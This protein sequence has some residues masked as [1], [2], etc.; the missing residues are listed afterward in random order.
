MSL[1]AFEGVLL[2]FLSLLTP[3]VMLKWLSSYIH[4]GRKS[5]GQILQP[6]IISFAALNTLAVVSRIITGN[7]N[8]WLF[9]KLADT[10]SFIPV[11]R[12]LKMYSR[13]THSQTRYAGR[14]SV[15]SQ[16]VVVAEYFALLMNGLDTCSKLL[17]LFGFLSNESL[18]SAEL[19]GMYGT[20]VYSFYT[21]ILCHGILLNALDETYIIGL[22]SSAAA[23]DDETRG[24]PSSSAPHTTRTSSSE[25]TVISSDED[26]DEE[27]AGDI[28]P[29][30]LARRM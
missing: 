19:K 24:T 29:L 12:T 27:V 15:L 21:R 14:G 22:S 30:Q 8:F 17:F 1:Q 7:E 10:L 26:E 13:V 25:P 23:C 28:V 4:L 6:W 5:P 11:M 16:T 2:C 9:K 3:Y 18:K 20:N